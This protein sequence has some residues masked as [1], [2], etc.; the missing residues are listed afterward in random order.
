MKSGGAAA[1]GCAAAPRPATRQYLLAILLIGWLFAAPGVPAAHASTTVEDMTEIRDSHADIGPALVDGQWR[2]Q[3]KDG[4][5]EPPIWR[6]PDDVILRVTDEA[7]HA[8]PD[9][10]TFDFLGAPGD[11]VFLIPQ[12]Q[13]PG[14][15]WL[16]WNTQHA[17][18]LA[19]PPANISFDLHDL[20]GP[21]DLHVYF[22]Y[23][24]FRPPQ[25]IWDSTMTGQQL[26][27]PSNTHAHA[28]WAFT[29]P[30]EYAVT[31]TATITTSTGDRV[32]PSA[33]LY[34][35]VGNNTRPS[36]PVPIVARLSPA[37]LAVMLIVAAGVVIFLLRRRVKRKRAGS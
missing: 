15:I 29:K 18:L 33:V 1:A 27:V 25:Q 26:D 32:S 7:E 37:L 2:I 21:G 20:D 8:L 22:D 6:N 13:L 4:A 16:G 9:D 23:G 10:E 14:V 12:T 11:P 19:D 35:L 17:N 28:N 36:Q 31:F 5:A 3:I 34:F 30:R 24:G